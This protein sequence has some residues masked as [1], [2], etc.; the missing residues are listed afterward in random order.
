MQRQKKQCLL[1]T[2]SNMKRIAIIVTMLVG[3]I[4]YPNIVEAQKVKDAFV[5][6]DVSGSMKYPQIN[7]EAISDPDLC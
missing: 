6:V 3:C 4:I 7:S 2:F 5:L 1:L